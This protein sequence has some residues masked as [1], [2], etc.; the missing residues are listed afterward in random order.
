VCRP[1]LLPVVP[2]QESNWAEG[3]HAH[4]ASDHNSGK[5]E[6]SISV[7]VVTKLKY[8]IL[9]RETGVIVQKVKKKTTF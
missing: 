2:P 6:K 9:Y 5:T 4:P 3:S 7:N 1:L 8:R